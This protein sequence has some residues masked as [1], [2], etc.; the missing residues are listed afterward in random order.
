MPQNASKLSNLSNP[1]LCFRS[2][3]RTF[4]YQSFLFFLHS[5]VLQGRVQRAVHAVRRA[6]LVGGLC[7]GGPGRVGP[8]GP[9][10]RRVPPRLPFGLERGGWAALEL[11]SLVYF[12]SLLRA[13]GVFL[14]LLLTA[15]VCS[16]RTESPLS[17]CT[18][19]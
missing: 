12:E 5:L 7:V 9:R 8:L 16:S 19:G 13:T 6:R 1:N 4:L 11:N 3:T 15:C 10:R 14:S 17:L 2:S 18:C